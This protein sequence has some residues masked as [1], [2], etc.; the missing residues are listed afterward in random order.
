MFGG[1]C[2]GGGSGDRERGDCAGSE[3]PTFV[4]WPHF[5]WD[6][7][8]LFC[9]VFV[10]IGG[11]R[12]FEGGNWEPERAKRASIEGVWAYGRMKFERL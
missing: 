7:V 1:R 2:P 10:Y 11:P 4:F 8:Y 3:Q 9:T 6:A 5:D 12:I